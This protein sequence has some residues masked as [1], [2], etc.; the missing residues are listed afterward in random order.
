VL[1][2]LLMNAIRSRGPKGGHSLWNPSLGGPSS[3]TW[4]VVTPLD[5]PLDEGGEAL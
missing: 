4:A 2:L 1:S 5:V 3:Y